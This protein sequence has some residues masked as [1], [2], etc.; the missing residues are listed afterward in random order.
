MKKVVKKTQISFK[1]Y[2]NWKNKY[3]SIAAIPLKKKKKKT[4]EVPNP[5][6]KSF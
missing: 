2:E 4:K 3:G 1:Q 6:A 5:K